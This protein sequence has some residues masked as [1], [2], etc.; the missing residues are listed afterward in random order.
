MLRYKRY[1]KSRLEAGLVL[2]RRRTTAA[3]KRP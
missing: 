2:P 3:S 1:F